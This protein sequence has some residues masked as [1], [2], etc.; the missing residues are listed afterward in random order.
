M[1]GGE[2]H[3]W[4]YLD[5]PSACLLNREIL[6]VRLGY[7]QLLRYNL[8]IIFFLFDNFL[9]FIIAII[10]WITLDRNLSIIT[11]FSIIVLILFYII[12]KKY[13]KSFQNLWKANKKQDKI[14]QRKRGKRV[15]SVRSFEITD[16]LLVNLSETVINSVTRS[17]FRVLSRELVP[18]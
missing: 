7:L 17:K 8:S 12:F 15:C 6:N 11:K 10:N 3:V 4:S 16:S 9:I 18:F 2:I 1:A 14:R 13:M 5:I